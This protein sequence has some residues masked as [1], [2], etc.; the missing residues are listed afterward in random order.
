MNENRTFPLALLFGIGFAFVLALFAAFVIQMAKTSR[1]DLPVIATVPEF[2]LT[3]RSGEP[4][5]HTDLPGTLWVVD[6]I[7]TN[8]QG[9]CPVMTRE[10]S[11]LYELYSNSE[12]IRFLSI[13]VDPERDTLEVLRN[14]AQS[15]GVTDD[16]WLF[17]RGPIEDVVRISEQ[18]F[19]LPA[20][21]LPMGHSTKFVLVDENSYIR[22]YYDA[23]NKAEVELMKTHIRELARKMK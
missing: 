5:S 10:M 12:K 21:N 15:H 13:S 2:T 1:A 18:G 22:G 6:F 19:L 23:L 16:R 4:V 8:C 9:A 20:E 17:T 14:Y 3:E 7:F 11:E